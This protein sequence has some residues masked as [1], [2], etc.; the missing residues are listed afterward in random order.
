M[1]MG[2][3]SVILEGGGGFPRGQMRRLIIARAIVGRPKILLLDEATSA[4]DNHT[5]AAVTDSLD[6]LHVT[7]LAVVLA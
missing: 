4:F 5:Q 7:R 1:P 6:R 3:P 2:M